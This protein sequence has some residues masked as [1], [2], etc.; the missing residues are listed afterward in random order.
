MVVAPIVQKLMPASLWKI[1][2]NLRT[3]G[4]NIESTLSSDMVFL[5]E[6]KL[7]YWTT[8]IFHVSENVNTTG[9]IEFENGTKVESIANRML[10]FPTKIKYRNI[11]NAG[12]FI[13]LNYFK[14]DKTNRLQEMQ[15]YGHNE[16][17]Y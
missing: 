14:I 12:V 3:L 16:K 6:Y 8:S 1:T 9:H 10:T 11:S 17:E 2:A 15:R 4:C 13:N 7:K 5:P